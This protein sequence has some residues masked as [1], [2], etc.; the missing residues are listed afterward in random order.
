MPRIFDAQ[1]LG[2]RAP[3]MPESVVKQTSLLEGL[4]TH[5]EGASLKLT[6][7]AIDGV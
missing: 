4:L 5:D 3:K 2:E 7:S 1:R 6:V